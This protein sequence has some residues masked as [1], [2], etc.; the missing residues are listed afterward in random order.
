VRILKCGLCRYERSS[1]DD[2]RIM[3]DDE[4]L[5]GSICDQ[6]LKKSDMMHELIVQGKTTLRTEHLSVE[7]DYTK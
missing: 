1:E 5:G 3:H 2:G 7:V 4:I 6:C